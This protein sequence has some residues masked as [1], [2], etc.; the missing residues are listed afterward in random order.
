MTTSLHRSWEHPRLVRRCKARAR[1]TDPALSALH[2]NDLAEA[3]TAPVEEWGGGGKKA[4]ELGHKERLSCLG[5]KETIPPTSVARARNWRA[6]NLASVEASV[7]EYRSEVGVIYSVHQRPRRLPGRVR[8]APSEKGWAQVLRKPRQARSMR[9]EDG[10]N[11]DGERAAS[12]SQPTEEEHL[13]LLD[14]HLSFALPTENAFR[15]GRGHTCCRPSSV[16][17]GLR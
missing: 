3:A 5:P 4:L 8:G 11:R 9:R 12:A 17:H 6:T 10:H 7:H 13:G 2:A 16:D 15:G 1:L 14:V